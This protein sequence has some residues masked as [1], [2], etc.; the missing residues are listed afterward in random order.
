MTI[1]I[2]S[3]RE[4][5]KIFQWQTV[6]NIDRYLCKYELIGYRCS[7]GKQILCVNYGIKFLQ[8]HTT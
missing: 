5:L 2:T 4:I 7:E 1:D 6:F 3:N 8:V